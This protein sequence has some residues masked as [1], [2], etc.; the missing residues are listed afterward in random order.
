MMYRVEAHF[1][2]RIAYNPEIEV[3]KIYKIDGKNVIFVL[4]QTD[5][6]QA[7]EKLREEV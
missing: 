4:K 1:A 5:I 6:P 7:M 3:G 2:I